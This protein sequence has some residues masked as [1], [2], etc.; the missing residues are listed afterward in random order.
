MSK[1]A[2]Y[3]RFAEKCVEVARFVKDANLKAQMLHM[4]Q[5][6]CRLAV[7]EPKKLEKEETD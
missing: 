2:K 3:Q 4:A 6:W 1:S 7:D 5:V